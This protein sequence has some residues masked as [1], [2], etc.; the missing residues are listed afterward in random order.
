MNRALDR[1]Y[2]PSR[3]MKKEGR[4]EGRGRE[5]GGREGERGG[6]E[7]GLPLSVTLFVPCNHSD[8]SIF[9]VKIWRHL[10]NTE[11]RRRL[12]KL[13]RAPSPLIPPTNSSMEKQA[14]I[15]QAILLLCKI[16]S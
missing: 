12:G 6:R 8:I 13:I 15:I 3:K 1:N 10:L 9:S 2:I 14:L 11:R 7:G 5:R 4:K 16:I